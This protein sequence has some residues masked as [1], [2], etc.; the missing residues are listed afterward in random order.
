MQ[1]RHQLSV[2]VMGIA[3]LTAT[4]GCD[5]VEQA[6]KAAQSDQTINHMKLT[7]RAFHNYHDIH[8]Q[9]PNNWEELIAFDTANAAAIQQLR[10]SGCE[11][12][13][14]GLAMKEIT[15]GSSNFVLAYMPDTKQES[16][17]ALYAD[18]SARRITAADLQS[19]LENQKDI[20]PAG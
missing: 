17:P 4:I 3:L 5:A 13:G 20:K 14:W 1:R 11:V 6:K 12:T 2:T 7:G 18:G 10:D 15:V 19:A 9:F 8:R 16:G